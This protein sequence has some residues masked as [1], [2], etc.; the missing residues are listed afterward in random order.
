M[1]KNGIRPCLCACLAAWT[2]VPAFAV[3][4]VP[5]TTVKPLLIA[6]IERGESH[7]VLTGESAN[8]M[9]GRFGSGAPIEIDVKTL[10]ARPQPGCKRLEVTTSQ[11]AVREDAKQAL[12][13]KQL[14]YLVSYCRD[15]RFPESK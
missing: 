15:G 6:A 8:F 11:N 12:S 13:N 7:G 5:V 4:R 10:R 9:R 2:L 14:T 3:Q 1:L